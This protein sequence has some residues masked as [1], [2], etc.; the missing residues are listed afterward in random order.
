MLN[1]GLTKEAFNSV[2]GTVMLIAPKNIKTITFVPEDVNQEKNAVGN[3]VKLVKSEQA[4][5]KKYNVKFEFNNN[6]T[7]FKTK[8]Y[9]ANEEEISSSGTSYNK[10]WRSINFTSSPSKII[11]FVSESIEESTYPFLLKK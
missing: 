1:P 9:N 5:E 3:I 6:D 7:F 11:V 8:A 4:G 10:G 2:S